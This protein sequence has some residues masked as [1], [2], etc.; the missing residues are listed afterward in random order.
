VLWITLVLNLLVSGTK[1]AVGTITATLSLVADGYHSL[2]DA[3]GNVLGLSTLGFAYKPPDEDHQYGH[4]KFEVLASMGIS[5]LLFATAFEIVHESWIRLKSA[6]APSMSLLSLAAAAGTLVVNLF[7]S[8]YETR[9][10]RRLRSPFLL[11]D[12]AHTR[13]DIFATLGVLA[14]IILIRAGYPWADPVAAIAIAAVIVAA[15][16]RILTT[17]V[18]IISDRRV[19]EPEA[20]TSVA[21]SFDGARRCR[22]VR[23]RGFEDA[24][25]LDLTI[26]LDPELSLKEAHD[27]CDRIEEA[28]REQFPQLVDIVIHQEPDEA[29]TAGVPGASSADA[30]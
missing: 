23:T 22:R 14:A 7:V 2:L 8:T 1:I 29:E 25:F 24:A 4:R 10:G 9:K 5:I 16:W 13:S 11:A 17:G 3:S 19:V 12:A 20:I 26:L 18:D 30:R 6:S 21:L 27:L 28:L 15:G